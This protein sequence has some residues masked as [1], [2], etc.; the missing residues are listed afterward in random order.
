MSRFAEE[1]ELFYWP[2]MSG[3][4]EVVRMLFAASGVTWK[5]NLDRNS[6][7]F[8]RNY[9]NQGNIGFAPPYI[10]DQ[11][12]G[13]VLAQLPAILQYVGEK[14]GL[15]PPDAAGKAAAMA[16]A[17]TIAD[18]WDGIYNCTKSFTDNKEEAPTRAFIG[19]RVKHFFKFFNEVLRRNGGM[20]M[21]GG[22]ITYADI[23]FFQTLEGFAHGFP[24]AYRTLTDTFPHV[25]SYHNQILTQ[26]PRL[27]EYMQGPK[28]IPF[29]KD[30]FFRKYPELNVDIN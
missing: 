11:S 24:R 30:V 14:H 13:L 5:D 22:R 9:Q 16:H 28:R 4:G 26:C 1:Y 3:R 12:N 8:H 15:A 17:L 29:D 20:F 27:A 21:C 2:G 23:F 25:Y 19:N 10:Q 18:L 6:V 7:M